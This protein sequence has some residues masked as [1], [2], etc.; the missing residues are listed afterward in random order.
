MAMP[1]FRENPEAY[2]LKLPKP[3]Y[4]RGNYKRPALP[5]SGKLIMPTM[6]DSTLI[7][8]LA[9]I[10]G[11][12]L[13]P[14]SLKGVAKPKFIE[15]DFGNCYIDQNY[16]RELAMSNCQLI[17]CGVNNFDYTL[18]KVPNGIQGESGK[19]YITDGQTSALICLHHPDIL[20]V[21]LWV[22]RV[23]NDEFIARCARAFVG[24]NECH[25]PVNRADK[26]TA[27]QTMGDP[28]ALA[29]AD[30]FRIHR[31]QPVRSNKSGNKSAA[32]ETR[33]LGT[34]Q[35]LYKRHGSDLL[36]RLCAVCSG[37]KYSP[38]TR[39]HVWA[40]MEILK[41]DMDKNK[42]DDERLINAIR[43]IADR[44]AIS[45]ATLNAKRRMWPVPRS[46]AELYMERYKK[47]ATAL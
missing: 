44:H 7:K 12:K 39:V 15:A 31:I 30:I 16:Q 42:I 45:E 8:P 41:P 29:V 13:E 2:G 22:V 36:S 14:K 38:I 11:L 33:L 5:D 19:I 27:L 6:Y 37:A 1:S 24:L 10:P 47:G 17:E 25:I 20:K 18:F 21:P 28:D 4:Q 43:S 26:F 46:L 40:L 3:V 35:S 32:G 34:L 23:S 9:V